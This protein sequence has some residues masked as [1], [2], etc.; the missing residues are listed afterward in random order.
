MTQLL[1][2]YVRTLLRDK[3]FAARPDLYL[4]DSLWSKFER[5]STTPHAM[6]DLWEA[7]YAHYYGDESWSGRT[8]GMTRRGDQGQIAAIRINRARRNSKARQALILAGLIRPKA[9]SSN[10]DAESAYATQLAEL[11]MEYDY[12]KG[13]LDSLWA[14]WV[15]QA[16]VFGDSYV[17]TRWVP[18]KGE[19]VGVMDGQPVYSGDIE[20]T[21]LP[22][23]LCE[24]D[25]SYPTTD[26]SPWAFVRTYEPKQDLVLNYTK[27]LDG[28][29]GD[30][31][32]DAIWDA[33]GDQRLERLSR[34]AAAE[35]NTACVVNF[36]HYPSPVM[37]LGL[38]VRMLDADVVLERRPLIG[39]GGDYDESTPKPLIRLAADEMTDTPHAWAPFWN[40]LAAQEL[41]DALLTSHATTVTTYNDPIYAVPAGSGNAPEKLSSGPGRRWTIPPN[42][43]PPTLIE[44]PEVKESA[45]KFD[46][47]IA[48][49]ME[50]DM[51]LNDAV[52]GRQDS[53]TKNAQADALQASQAV[54][55][56]APAARAARVALSKLFELRL[57]T[58]RKN[59]QG[60]RLLRIIGRSKQHLLL[61]SKTFSAK[62]LSPFEG[63]ELEDS[64]PMEAT[65][66]G[67]WAIVQ[68]R[69]SMGLIKSNE[70]LDMV[71]ETGRL[72]AVVD[73]VHDENLLIKAE[74]DAIRRGENPPV[75]VTQ[76]MVL[77]M[78]QHMTTTMSPAA[79]KDQK[80]L[81]AWQAHTNVHY[82]QYFGLP[83]GVPM[84]QDPL[85][86]ARWK[87]VMGLGPEPVPPPQM[88]PPGAP[89][90][91]GAAGAPPP[92]AAP[93]GPPPDAKGPPKPPSDM[94]PPGPGAVPDVKNLLNGQPFS[95]TQPPLGGGS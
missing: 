11:I 84:E 22:P 71:M 91:P 81:G 10:N 68:L 33:R 40:I 80:V 75:Y 53:A 17:F 20:T 5:L 21:V 30:R 82:A 85:F 24:G 76:N 29:E 45:I 7:S 57:K 79:L 66:Q 37:P 19:Q 83:P 26:A 59:S 87:F 39:D 18:W 95:N 52:F 63:V 12:K 13:G 15:E 6:G 60:D 62:Q 56:V 77:H 41:S 32:A 89:P 16:E 70:D 43:Q 78:R 73:P 51:A 25:E 48:N 88:G 31:V 23:W 92:G 36:F 64:N 93:S 46:E 4:G 58:I 27:L 47:V 3:Y 94:P 50:Q 34:V 2:P 65:S 44:R 54:Q 90:P 35:H 9:R 55:Q 42:A 14:Q 49:E 28:R 61:D 8:W 69:Q 1:T 67:R 86:H 38:F 74:N 72:E